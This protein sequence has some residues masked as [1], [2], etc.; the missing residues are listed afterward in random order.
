MHRP[1]VPFSVP[2]PLTHTR[3]SSDFITITC[4]FRFSVH[5]VLDPVIGYRKVSIGERDNEAE[6]G[7]GRRR[8]EQHANKRAQS[9]CR[10]R[11]GENATYGLWISRA[12]RGG[13]PHQL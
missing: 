13:R 4:G 8:A 12:C 10:N 3:S 6:G 7:R 5:T 11:R 1:F 9:D 2:E